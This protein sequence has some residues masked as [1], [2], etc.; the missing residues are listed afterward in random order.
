MDTMHLL[1]R[2]RHQL[3]FVMV[4]FGLILDAHAADPIR[5][6]PVK[7]NQDL[8][9]MQVATGWISFVDRKNSRVFLQPAKPFLG[10]LRYGSDTIVLWPVQVQLSV[11]AS[12]LT[13]TTIDGKKAHF[14]DL[15]VGQA[16][17][18]QYI[19]RFWNAGGPFSSLSCFAQ[20]IDAQTAKRKSGR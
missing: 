12:A 5:L 6:V 15:A 3:A 19:L 9:A 18:I 1:W 2:V 7:T 10:P 4:A 13:P 8:N 17:T 11:W 16:A 14:T 20:R